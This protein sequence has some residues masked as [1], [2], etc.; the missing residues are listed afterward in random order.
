MMKIDLD[1]KWCITSGSHCNAIL[2][3][4]LSNTLKMVFQQVSEH[5]N[6]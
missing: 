4:K 5:E 6:S 1:D 2:I 3:K